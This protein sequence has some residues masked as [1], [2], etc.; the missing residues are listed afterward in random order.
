[1]STL[2]RAKA[3]ES[4]G[5]LQRARRDC[6]CGRTARTCVSEECRLRSQDNGKNIE[7]RGG[8]GEGEGEGR[9]GEE[10]RRR[11]RGDLS[12]CSALLH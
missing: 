8:E 11:G 12:N 9:G 4:S 2:G 1:M 5:S 6:M 10:E 3:E 7:G